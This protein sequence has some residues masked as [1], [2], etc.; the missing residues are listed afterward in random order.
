MT[1]DEINNGNK[2]IAE[3]MGYKLNGNI[4]K[5]A[6]LDPD[7]FDSWDQLVGYNISQAKYDTSWDWLMPV[8][9]KIELL[10]NRM[11]LFGVARFGVKIE[12]VWVKG[13]TKGIYHKCWEDQGVDSK[14]LSSWVGVIEFIKWYTLPLMERP[15]IRYNCARCGEDSPEYLCKRC[16]A[17]YILG[18]K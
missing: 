1:Q 7:G 2:I 10:D 5:S 3:F 9:D 16:E 18:I 6:P 14:I 4:V 17:K 15:Y 13:L 11:Y 8:I 12:E